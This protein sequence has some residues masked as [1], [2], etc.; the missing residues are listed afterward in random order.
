MSVTATKVRTSD[1]AIRNGPWAGDRCRVCD[2]TRL[3]YYGTPYAIHWRGHWFGCC[4]ACATD[5]INERYR[6]RRR[7]ARAD[8]TCGTCGQTFTPTRSDGRYCSS[9]CRQRAYRGRQ[10]AEE[11]PA[12]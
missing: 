7:R 11:T 5:A 2:S 8:R 9:A 10:R 12:A 4:T 6:E 3:A 1:L